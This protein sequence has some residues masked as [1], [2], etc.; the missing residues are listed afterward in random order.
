MNF[1]TECFGEELLKFFHWWFGNIVTRHGQILIYLLTF[2]DKE[3]VDRNER[4]LKSIDKEANIYT[5]I[6]IWE[7]SSLMRWI[8]TYTIERGKRAIFVC[9]LLH[10]VQNILEKLLGFTHP[11]CSRLLRKTGKMAYTQGWL[12]ILLSL[13]KERKYNIEQYGYYSSID[14]SL[15]L[16][17]LLSNLLLLVTESLTTWISRSINDWFRFS[18]ISDKNHCILTGFPL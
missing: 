17:F 4:N 8:D 11:F 14:F 5:Y 3:K 7:Y 16:F 15:S 2:T 10:T 9:I 6:C 13:E 1:F 12:I 18:N